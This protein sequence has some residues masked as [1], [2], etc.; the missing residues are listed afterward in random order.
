[1]AQG[2]KAAESIDDYL[3]YGRVRSTRKQRMG[4]LFQGRPE[5]R[6]GLLKVPVRPRPRI[7]AEELDPAVRKRI[8]EEVEKP[9]TTDQAYKEA[10]R[11]MRCY[12]VSM[13]VTEH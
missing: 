10:S 1:M 11:C 13:A 7:I 8:F 3:T 12:R 4:N 6:Q 2:D 5:T 9:I